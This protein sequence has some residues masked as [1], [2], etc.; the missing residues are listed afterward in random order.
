LICLFHMPNILHKK[1][2]SPASARLYVLTFK[3]N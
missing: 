1:K 2:K 3:S